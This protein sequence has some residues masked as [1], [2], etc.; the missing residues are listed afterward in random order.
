LPVRAR[1]VHAALLHQSR[2]AQRDR[3]KAKHRADVT[4]DET[5]AATDIKVR[6]F[7]RVTEIQPFLKA[8]PPAKYV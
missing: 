7:D 5:D 2:D 1:K 4:A 6:L 8:L 3:R